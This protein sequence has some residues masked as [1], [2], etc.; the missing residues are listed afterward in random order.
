MRRPQIKKARDRAKELI[1]RYHITRPAIPIED[2]TKALGLS[3][4]YSKLDNEISGMIYINDGVPI[5]GINVAHHENR[6][7]FTLAHECGHFLL[8]QEYI[9]GSVH[10]DKRYPV[11]LRSD[12]S[13]QGVDPIEIEANQFAAE[14]LVPEEF[15]IQEIQ[16]TVYDIEDD[17]FIL[18]LAR[19]FKVSSQMMS[20]CLAN[21][22]LH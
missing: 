22:R 20:N 21:I 17:E 10:V 16:I 6:Q 14:L 4:Q 5:I 12:V 19:K 7:R 15:L 9:F 3:V 11:L 13:S 8:H 18:G 2:I 1:S